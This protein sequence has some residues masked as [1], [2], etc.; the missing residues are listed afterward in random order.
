MLGLKTEVC[1][2]SG[3]GGRGV[4]GIAPGKKFADPRPDD[5]AVVV[6]EV[7]FGESAAMFESMLL[8]NVS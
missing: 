5:G 4:E 2:S 6:V 7:L 1:E 8:K 3:D